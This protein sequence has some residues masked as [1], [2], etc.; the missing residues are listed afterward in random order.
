MRNGIQLR[1]NDDMPEDALRVLDMFLQVW[2][3]KDCK[4]PVTIRKWDDHIT[5]HTMYEINPE[6]DEDVCFIKIKGIPRNLQN[7]V[8]IH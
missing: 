4:S 7:Y 6:S 3:D 5:R 8:V 1:I 2:L